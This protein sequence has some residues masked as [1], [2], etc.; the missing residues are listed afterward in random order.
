[1]GVLDRYKANF[2]S[3]TRPL[4]HTGGE[5]D[6]ER[7]Q[8]L[9]DSF[10]LYLNDQL[11]LMRRAPTQG[12]EGQPAQRA[13]YPKPSAQHP[14]GIE[15]PLR[16]GHGTVVV[17]H[18]EDGKPKDSIWAAN[19]GEMEEVVTAFVQE[20]AAGEHDVILMEADSHHASPPPSSGQPARRA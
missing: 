10:S 17:G 18:A 3:A 13:W 1:M 16:Y 11:A 15:L 6:P 14:E 5:P 4:G 9:R 20:V 7:M 19:V 12:K 8:R 2:V